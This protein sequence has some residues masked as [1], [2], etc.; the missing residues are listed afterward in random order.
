MGKRYW[1]S[2][3]AEGQRSE[4]T[5]VPSLQVLPAERFSIRDQLTR[6]VDHVLRSRAQSLELIARWLMVWMSDEEARAPVATAYQYVMLDLTSWVWTRLAKEATPS[7]EPWRSVLRRVE[8][9][10]RLHGLTD[11][12]RRT[13]EDA[14]SVEPGWDCDLDSWPGVAPGTAAYLILD[15]ETAEAA[16]RYQALAKEASG[17]RW[18]EWARLRGVQWCARTQRFRGEDSTPSMTDAELEQLARRIDELADSPIVRARSV[19]M[20]SE[21]HEAAERGLE[22]AIA[23]G[24][25]TSADVAEAWKRYRYLLGAEASL[26]ELGRLAKTLYL[27]SGEPRSWLELGLD[28][29]VG[30][31]RRALAA[32]IEM[33]LEQPDAAVTR[34]TAAR[35]VLEQGPEHRRGLLNRLS[36]VPALAPVL[37]EESSARIPELVRRCT[38]RVGRSVDDATGWA[39]VFPSSYVEAMRGHAKATPDAR[40]LDG[41]RQLSEW[42]GRPDVAASAHAMPWATSWLL[43]EARRPELEHEVVALAQTWRE[44]MQRPVPGGASAL[45]PAAELLGLDEIPPRRLG[46]SLEA[47]A[48]DAM[49]VS[50]SSKYAPWIR[51]CLIILHRL[52]R[53]VDFGPLVGKVGEILLRVVAHAKPMDVAS[54]IASWFEFIADVERWSPPGR[55]DS[56]WE[57]FSS[58]LELDVLDAPMWDDHR[59]QLARGRLITGSGRTATT[60]QGLL[61]MARLYGRDDG[62]RQWCLVEAFE[63]F[64]ENP[65]DF[66]DSALVLDPALWGPDRWP[67]IERSLRLHA[68]GL[69]SSSDPR[70]QPPSPTFA[71]ISAFGLSIEVLHDMARCALRP[72]DVAIPGSVYRAAVTSMTA[73]DGVLANHAC[74]LLVYALGYGVTE[75]DAELCDAL[76]AAAADRRWKVRLAAAFASTWLARASDGRLVGLAEDLRRRLADEDHAALLR[77]VALGRVSNP[78]PR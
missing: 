78:A 66:Y 72:S 53:P 28:W 12:L 74:F 24:A 27:S 71:R 77:Q 32:R 18:L 14:R 3:T 59:A 51:P 67:V 30:S 38:E 4:P 37:T 15:G 36:A 70:G 54:A 50:L 21:R 60:V 10:C 58:L 69:S 64:Q 20:L 49:K 16:E 33:A 44:S 17:D 7:S 29:D 6:A 46:S 55:W 63:L 9:L 47:L 52:T 11:L 56:L 8:A 31:G 43:D 42:A 23:D 13:A 39:Q 1:A 2:L 19:S 61:A 22:R 75:P 35:W 45:W 48:R 34:S 41:W 26:G 73:E 76:R 57:G 5:L 40:W 65:T 68:V 62:Y 25:A